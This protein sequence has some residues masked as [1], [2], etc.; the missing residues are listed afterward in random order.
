MPLQGEGAGESPGSTGRY[1]EGGT[2]LEIKAE[3]SV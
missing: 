1:E 3:E 2:S